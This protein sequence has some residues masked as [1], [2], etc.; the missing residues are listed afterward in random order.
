MALRRVSGL[1]V[2]ASLFLLVLH[3]GTQALG[4][5]E[6][7]DPS[8]RTIQAVQLRQGNIPGSMLVILGMDKQANYFTRMKAVRE[9]GDELA[10]L[11]IECLYALMYRHEGEDSLRSSS[12]NAIKNE[13]ANILRNQKDA[14]PDLAEHFIA[15][16]EEGEQDQVWRDYCVQ[17][18]G[19]MY[20]E[21]RS[22]E[23][24]KRICT[25]LW[26][27]AEEEEAIA[28]TALLAL[29]K[30]IDDG[31]IRRD[32]VAE[33]ALSL[34]SDDDVARLIRITALQICADLEEERALPV[35]TR[36]T[37]AGNTIALRM[38]AIAALGKIGAASSQAI[39]IEYANSS[40]VRLRKAGKSAL[41]RWKAA[42]G[43]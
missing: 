42:N 22:P 3:I 43:P 7:P 35:A 4:S 34:C 25:T 10:P 8:A 20:P 23:Q 13:A 32:D 15:M 9:L 5:A 6:F 11:E 41:A 36:L 24:A 33:K 17:H 39:L 26:S 29:Y 31:L 38:S 16:I 37:G 27:V 30:N 40:D 1:V 28:G 18:L 14:P 21:S 12:L 19:A 2:W